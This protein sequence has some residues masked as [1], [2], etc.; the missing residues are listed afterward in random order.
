MRL[1]V[2]VFV[3]AQVSAAWADDPAR[4]Q[5]KADAEALAKEARRL[6]DRQRL[7]DC[8][9][10]FL[11]LYNKDPVAADYEE[12][13]FNSGQC[14]DDAGAI[15]AAIQIYKIL[16][17]YSMS[18]SPYAGTA[19]ARESVL[20]EQV[21]LLDSAATGFEKLATKYPTHKDAKDGVLAAIRLRGLL[22]QER[23]L[24]DATAMFERQHGAKDPIRAA[25]LELAAAGG[26]RE[27]PFEKGRHLRQL[28]KTYSGK[29]PDELIARAQA[30]LGA[31]LWE[32]ACNTIATSD[33]LCVDATDDRPLPLAAQPVKLA[34]GAPHCGR[35]TARFQTTA[36]DPKLVQEALAAFAEAD[37]RFARGGTLSVDGQRARARMRLVLADRELEAFLALGVGEPSKKMAAATKVVAA[38]RALASEPT[39]ALA[40]AARQARVWQQIATQLATAEIPAP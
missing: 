1:V 4:D 14:Y 32:R 17:T 29:A 8:G 40:I 11:D 28:L 38:Y 36:R 33:G 15:G 2:A 20:L 21:G 13:L 26:Y 30:E 19:L 16:V 27:N 39:L 18:S 37:K 6:G 35:P 7:M 10:A 9:Q 31:T 24:L 34:T 22:G 5:E 12:L 3:L 23:Q 25:E